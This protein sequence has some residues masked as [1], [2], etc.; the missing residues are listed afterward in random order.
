MESTLT[1][2]IE[3]DRRTAAVLY[4]VE[5]SR[6]MFTSFQLLVVR[7][8]EQKVWDWKS[9]PSFPIAERLSLALEIGTSK[10]EHACLPMAA[11]CAGIWVPGCRTAARHRIAITVLMTGRCKYQDMV[12]LSNWAEKHPE[13]VSPVE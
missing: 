12:K 13:P 8:E 7:V 1:K 6:G 11:R 9:I 5:C 3:K 4:R 2:K 10:P